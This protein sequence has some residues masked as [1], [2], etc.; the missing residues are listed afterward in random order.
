MRG[1]SLD[2]RIVFQSAS[3][4]RDSHGEPIA[5]WSTFATVWAQRKDVRSQERF[6]SD[7]RLAVR[8]AMFRLY[9][10]AGIDEAMRIIDDGATYE[11]TGI[12]GN[13]RQNWMEITAAVNNPAVST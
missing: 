3:E 2:R 5:T 9:W 6:T 7:Q 12:A 8:S 4:V 11:I 13:K 10:L 1:G